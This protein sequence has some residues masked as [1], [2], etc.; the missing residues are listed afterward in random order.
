M[1]SRRSVLVLQGDLED[2]EILKML[3]VLTDKL[4]GVR[5]PADLFSLVCASG[6]AG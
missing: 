4:E 2:E 5:K 1:A 3:Q 6:A